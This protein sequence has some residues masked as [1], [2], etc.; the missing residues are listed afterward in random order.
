MFLREALS[1]ERTSHLIADVAKALCLDGALVPLRSDMVLFT[2]RP[3]RNLEGGF[4]R[5]TAKFDDAN[6]DTAQH[7]RRRL[8]TKIEASP[9]ICH[10]E[11]C[12]VCVLVFVG[13]K[14]TRGVN[15]PRFVDVLSVLQA[16]QGMR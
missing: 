4:C 14:V 16:E 9:H 1:E 8:S 5:R 6:L 11:A 12:C 2:G 13:H 10:I 7:N 3:D 15:L